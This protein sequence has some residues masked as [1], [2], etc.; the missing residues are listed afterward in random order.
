MGAHRLGSQGRCACSSRPPFTPHA[1]PAPST[2]TH[3][4]ARG[5]QGQPD[6]AT[7]ERTAGTFQRLAARGRLRKLS[8]R[9]Y[10]PVQRGCI[11][12]QP[13]QDHPPN[14]VSGSTSQE[15]AQSKYSVYVALMLPPDG[16]FPGEVPGNRRRVHICMHTC[17]PPW[18]LSGPRVG[19]G[20]IPC[21]SRGSY[22]PSLHSKTRCGQATSFYQ[23]S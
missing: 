10:F 11:H 13:T 15:V 12:M 3:R 20:N 4:D 2:G 23:P 5:P 14:T 9:S 1:E 18:Q 17:R 6:R 21:L 22:L 7:R 8:R 16:W 19:S